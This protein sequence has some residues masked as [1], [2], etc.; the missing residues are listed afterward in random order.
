VIWQLIDPTK[1]LTFAVFLLLAAASLFSW[2]VVFAK[3]G[4]F[5]R[6]RQSNLNFLRAF[7]KAGA[8]DQ[9]SLA[10]EQFRGAPLATVF[11][12]GYA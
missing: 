8:L 12:Y 5:R 1:P 9:L 6:L 7:R 2:T 3:W 11:E 10:L 4:R